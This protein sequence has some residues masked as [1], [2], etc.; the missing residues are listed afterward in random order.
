MEVSRRLQVT[1]DTVRTWRRR[2]LE[3]GL[4]GLFRRA[5]ARCPDDQPGCGHRAD[6]VGQRD[7]RALRRRRQAGGSGRNVASE[8]WERTSSG[9]TSRRRRAGASRPPRPAWCRPAAAP[10]W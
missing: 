1:P 10:V 8:V 6:R 3:R 2:F 7:R 4:D 5:A 9:T